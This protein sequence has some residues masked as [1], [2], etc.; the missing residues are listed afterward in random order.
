MMNSRWTEAYKAYKADEEQGLMVATPL[1]EFEQI[2]FKAL[3]LS[4]AKRDEI[5]LLWAAWEWNLY[6][7]AVKKLIRDLA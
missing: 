7:I 1:T 3:T 6:P 5:G 4:L 2:R